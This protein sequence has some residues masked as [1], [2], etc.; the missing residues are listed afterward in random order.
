M[1]KIIERL[2]PSDKERFWSKVDVSNP[3]GCWPW[4]DSLTP[5]GYG[6]FS[7]GSKE[8]QTKL[9]AHRVA[10]TLSMGEDI[11]D[12]KIVMHMCDNPPCCNPDHLGVA[13]HQENMDDMVSK[14]RS[15][16]SFGRAKLDWETVDC[17]LT[18]QQ[19]TGV[20]WAEMLG[21]SKGTISEIRNRKIW[22]D[23]DR[24]VALL[25]K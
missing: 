24:E 5:D 6:R 8:T 2:T 25:P 4:T 1:S 21:V 23:E 15:V 14:K 20:Q 19:V 3:D 10:K 7:V 18:Y 11:P 16:R 12:G 9:A 22:R 17:I 13:T